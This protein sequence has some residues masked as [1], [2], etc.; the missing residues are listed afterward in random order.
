MTCHVYRHQKKF[1]LSKAVI[2]FLT[3]E[4]ENQS[5]QFCVDNFCSIFIK[6]LPPITTSNYWYINLKCSCHTSLLTREWL[7]T[8]FPDRHISRLTNFPWPSRSPDLSVSD[9]FVWGALK[10]K[11][12]KTPVLSTDELKLR[13]RL[14]INNLDEDVI[15]KAFQSYVNRLHEC[16]HVKGRHVTN[17]SHHKQPPVH[18]H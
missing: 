12:F 7:Q 2:K 11:V 14:E 4:K 13:I 1:F 5:Y 8:K 9:F 3:I 18:I 10:D 6:I 16:I 15:H 17:I